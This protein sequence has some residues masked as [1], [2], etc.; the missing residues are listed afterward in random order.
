MSRPC[1]AI[2]AEPAARTLSSVRRCFRVIFD[3]ARRVRKVLIKLCV[4][5]RCLYACV[6][7]FTHTYE[8]TISVHAHYA[9]SLFTYPKSRGAHPARALRGR[10][11]VA[12]YYSAVETASVR[13]SLTRAVCP[14]AIMRLC[15]CTSALSG[16]TKC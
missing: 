13:T 5:L 16:G 1:A 4:N 11:L 15:S 12:S 9:L 6:C 14:L 10:R 8:C 7:V 2:N 3:V